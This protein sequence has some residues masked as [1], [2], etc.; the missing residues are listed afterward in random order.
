MKYIHYCLVVLVVLSFAAEANGKVIT[1]SIEYK[2][3]ETVLEGYLAY[4]DS[5]AGKRP[6]ILVIHEWWGLNDYVKK[7]ADQLAELGYVAFAA[8][9]YGKGVLANDSQEASRLAG[10][11]KDTALL[12]DRA[13][14][15]LGVL[16]EN[17]FVDLKRIAAI[18]FCFGG[19]TVFEL[20]YGGAPLAGAVSFHG[21]LPVPKQED[22]NNIKARLLALHGGEDPFVNSDKVNAFQGFMRQTEVDWQ[23]II[24]GG[25]VH[26]FSNPSSGNDKSKGA[27]YNEK[28]AKRAWEHMQLFFKELFHQ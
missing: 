25:A 21:G 2:H 13:R 16:T 8:D 11:F 27:A 6:G 18:G 9:M 1:K 7:R 23:M 14:S 24:Y 20:A 3:D 10:Q 12:R 26:S 4:D 17:G 5:I 19:T 22:I 28:A 15:G